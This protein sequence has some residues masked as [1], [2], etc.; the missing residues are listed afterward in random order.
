[1]KAICALTL[2]FGA[3][4]VAG[5]SASKKQTPPDVYLVSID[6]LRADHV[7]CYGYKDIQTPALDS[8]AKDGV[9]FAQAFTPSP[10]TNTS[11]TTILTGL[12]PSSHGVTDFAVPLAATHA[13]WAELLKGRG[14][15]T[16]AFI[17]AVILDSHSLAPGLD[18][19][20][21]FYDDFPN[22]LPSQ[23]HWGRVE[24]R[25]MDVVGRAERWLTAHPAGPRF[26]WV[27]LYDPHDPYEPPAPYSQIYKDRL[28]DGEIAYAD[29][30]LG[31]FVEYIKKRGWYENAIVIVVGDHGEGLGEHGEDTH[32]IFLYDS[33]THVPLILKLPRNIDSGKVIDTQVRTTDILPTGLDLLA[34]PAS[35][36]FDGE[37]LKPF[38]SGA[39]PGARIAFGET[40]YPLRF[41]WAPLR[42]V[43]EQ[44]FKFIEAPRPELYDLH[45]DPG[46]VHNTYVPWDEKVQKS[47]SM[48]AEMRAKM[49]PPAPSAATVPA[50][51]VDELKALGYLGQADVGS[52]TDVPEPS[53]LPDPKDKIQE[54][55]LLHTAMMAEED[56]RPSDARA[57]LEKVLQLDPKSPT[58]LRQIGQLELKAGDYA[59]A[60]EHL[61]TAREIRP[62]DAAAAFDEGQA[63]EKLG[64][65]AGAREALETSLKLSPGQLAARVLLGRVYLK[66]NDPKVAEDQFEAAT[67]LDSKSLDAQLGVAQAEIA[68]GKQSAALDHL[69]SL[70]ASHPKEPQI[71]DLLGE[72]YRGLGNE[73]EAGQAEARAE[74]LRRTERR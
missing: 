30:A 1:M 32:G 6:T 24:R 51:T 49:P 69:K 47:R 11:H 5:Q 70:S 2:C 14:Y 15:H 25:G 72:A 27:H 22:N 57:S 45:Q 67:L 21:D 34:I 68:E 74:L 71:F 50:G 16:A 3:T 20:F 23:V 42:S 10:I 48:L 19:G 53:L 37:S 43:R 31:N 63:R 38:L 28:Y 13:T 44:G 60:A 9:R 64:D 26:V 65:F 59:K 7:R 61:H 52:S 35:A 4:L 56:N 12:L 40:D 62:N 8:L 58:A 66:L 39:R 36:K 55:N 73:K 41:G 54:A 17:G 29:S 46:E 18:R 33:T